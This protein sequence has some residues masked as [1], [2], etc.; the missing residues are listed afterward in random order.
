MLKIVAYAARTA[1]SEKTGKDYVSQTIEIV[2]SPERP[3]VTMRRFAKTEADA[4]KPGQYTCK[5]SFFNKGLD[6]SQSF[7][8][9]Q[10]V[11]SSK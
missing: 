1:R 6:L 11:A 9:F 10:P 5:V 8:D 7:Y 2:Q 3:N 4:L